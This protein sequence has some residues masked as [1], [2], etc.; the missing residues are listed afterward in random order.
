MRQVTH[1]LGKGTLKLHIFHTKMLKQAEL[2]DLRWQNTH[3]GG[4]GQIDIAE[5]LHLTDVIWEGAR[6]P[7][8]VLNMEELELVQFGKL[9]GG[10]SF[11]GVGD[12]RELS[13]ISGSVGYAS[14]VGDTVLGQE[15]VLY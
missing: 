14:H 2:A 6:N 5:V 3:Q 4:V 1:L 12:E 13:E 11:K 8:A 9:F 15:K 7:R 10:L